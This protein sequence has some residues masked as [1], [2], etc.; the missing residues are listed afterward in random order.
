M[1]AATTGVHNGVGQTVRVSEL[2]GTSKNLVGSLALYEGLRNKLTGAG[3]TSLG[4]RGY[5]H[6][7]DGPFMESTTNSDKMTLG[8]GILLPGHGSHP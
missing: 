1:G 2:T 6:V 7:Y 5:G 3:R 4:K 8:D